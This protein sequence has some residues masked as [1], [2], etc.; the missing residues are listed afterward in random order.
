MTLKHL[1]WLPLI[2][3]CVQVFSQP[4]NLQAIKTTQPPKI[5]GSLDDASWQSAAVATD[6]IQNF[7]QTGQPASAKTEVKVLYDDN[8]IYIG[9][10]IYDDPSL[11]RKQ[12]TARDGEQRSDVDYFSVFFDTYK[13]KQNGFQ[14]LVTS[15]NVQSD[16]K[17]A[18]N[19]QLEFDQYGDKTWDAVWQSKTSIVSNGWI[20]EIR[21]PYISLRFSKNEVQEWGLQFMRF[22]RRNN[23]RSFWNNV[24]PNTNGFVNQFGELSGIVNV[25]PPLR[26]S[27]SP[28]VSGG[29]RVAP[30]KNIN[31][32]DWLKRGGMDIKYGLNESFT[33]DATLVPDFGQVISDNVVLN[34]SPFEVQFQE[35]RPFFTEGTE[36]FNKAGLFYSRRVGATPSGF[37]GIRDMVAADPNLEIVKNHS[38]TQLINAVKFSGRNKKKL[39]IGLFNAVSAPMHAITRNKTTGEETTTLTSPLTNYNIFV[40]DQ[41]LKGRSSI[42]FTNTNVMRNG[43]DRDANVS[44]FD[45]SLFNKKNIYGF[46]GSARYSK[47]YGTNPYDGFNTSLLLKKVSGKIQFNAGVDI[48]S[49]KYDPNDLGFLL[50]NNQVNYTGSLTYNQFVPKGNFLTYRYTLKF[51]YNWLYKPYVFTRFEPRLIA[52]WVFRN[53]W[54]VSV[55]AGILPNG[56]NDYFELRKPGRFVKKP[57]Y[58]FNWISGSSDSRKKLYFSYGYQWGWGKG[59]GYPFSYY[60]ASMGLRYR[61]GEKFSMELSSERNEEYGQV[62]YVFANEINGEPIAGRRTY[63]DV[64]SIFSGRYNFTSRLNLSLRGR[65]YWSHVTYRSFHNV[66]PATGELIPRAFNTTFA[67]P[68]E[69]FNVFNLDAFLT[70]DFN[71]GSRIIL[72]WKNFLGDGQYID[73]L[74]HRRYLNNLGETFD[75]R[76]G[77]ELTIRFI[78]FLDYNQL[79][80]KR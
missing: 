74:M 25:Q 10:M 63:T 48:L 4:K 78:Y 42:T 16:A 13:D 23:E 20:A 51:F 58:W 68:N 24:D 77:N 30:Q 5:D 35:N 29:F 80:R 79:K 44:A 70:W 19:Q 3:V 61:I 37:Y 60:L 45:F 72:G 76:H 50:K 55:T 53:F 47:I 65:H 7:P 1:F 41:A 64:N 22:I 14:F 27:L 62:G 69:N 66:S 21:I 38:V 40:L 67:D 18:P 8:A 59:S 17:M 15:V 34:L 75:L 57:S 31:Y 52:F 39:G 32:T 36:L 49:D 73:G 54:D 33:V 28:Y 12:L 9:A 43:V 2:L 71:L 11:I 46:S 56:E 26:L 6:F